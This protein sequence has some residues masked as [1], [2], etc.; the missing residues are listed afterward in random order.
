MAHGALVLLPLLSLELPMLQ[1]F[2]L[3]ARGIGEGG[4]SPSRMRSSTNTGPQTVSPETKIDL[5]RGKVGAQ[6]PT[7]V[8]PRSRL[9]LPPDI[10]TQNQTKLEFPTWALIEK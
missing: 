6:V 9:R 8:E 10:P 2:W 3:L 1:A 5:V 7:R 4:A